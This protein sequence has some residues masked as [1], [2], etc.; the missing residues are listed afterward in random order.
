MLWWNLIKNISRYKR[1]ESYQIARVAAARSIPTKTASRL[2]AI[3]HRRRQF[4]APGYEDNLAEFIASFCKNLCLTLC[5]DVAGQV[6]III[7]D[8]VGVEINLPLGGEMKGATTRM[9]VIL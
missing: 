2:N 6:C 9:E 8:G 3:A 1:H 4:S 5:A 7:D